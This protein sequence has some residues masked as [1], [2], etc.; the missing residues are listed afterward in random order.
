M[1]KLMSLLAILVLVV[2]IPCNLS[3]AEEKPIELSIPENMPEEYLGFYWI[4]GNETNGVTF[5]V[6]EV[7]YNEGVLRISVIQLPNDDYTAIIDNQVE[8]TTDRRYLDEKIE[9]ASQYG[10]KILGTLCDIESIVDENGNNLLTEYKVS[11]DQNE[12]SMVTVFEI[13]LPPENTIKTVDVGL[14]FGVNE[15]LGYHFPMSDSMYLT[16][17]IHQLAATK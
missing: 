13:F 3:F 11:G 17:P 2:H 16:I 7:H 14:V 8:D 1:K 4:G 9:F 12:S 6:N 5:V 10:D 15:D